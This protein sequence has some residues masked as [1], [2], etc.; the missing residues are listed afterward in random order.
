MKQEIKDIGVGL[1]TSA[2][3]TAWAFLTQVT[4]AEWVAI[5]VG[6]INVVL[7]LRKWWRDETEWGL[8]MKRWANRKTTGPMD[9][10]EA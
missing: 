8:K 1:L 7:M 9:L 6:T 5:I 3:T 2:P 10:D 4:I